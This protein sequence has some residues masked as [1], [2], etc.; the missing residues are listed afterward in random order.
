MTG[1]LH[2]M[3]RAVGRIEAQIENINTDVLANREVAD[4]RH[5]ET[6]KMFKDIAARLDRLETGL[7]D[8]PQMKADV[9][10]MK[11]FYARMSGISAAAFA[12][13]SA[14]I[15]L[16]WN[17]AAWVAAKVDWSALLKALALKG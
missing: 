10:N 7:T 16:V 8:V 12:T 2:E 1:Q 3:S 9:A 5:M 4:R 14:G 6:A 15:W 17:G 13:V 11:V